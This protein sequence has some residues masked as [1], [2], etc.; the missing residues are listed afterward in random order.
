MVGIKP[1]ANCLLLNVGVGSIVR[2]VH[3]RKAQ[4]SFW[5]IPFTVCTFISVFVGYH[6][7][8]IC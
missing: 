4:W 7:K 3:Y 8:W 1:C 2:E 6:V 5:K